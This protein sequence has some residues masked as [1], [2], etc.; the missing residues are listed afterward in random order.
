VPTDVKAGVSA[1]VILVALGLVYWDGSPIQPAFDKIV[2]LTAAFFVL[3]MWIFPEGEQRKP[4]ASCARQG[5]ASAG[6]SFD[7]VH[8]DI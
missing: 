4:A 2:L 7:P 3:A 6:P 5:P 1:A 8:Q